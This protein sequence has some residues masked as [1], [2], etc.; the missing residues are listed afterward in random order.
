MKPCRLAIISSHPIQYYAP[1]FRY[2]QKETDLD[3]K[4]FYLKDPQAKADLDQGFKRVVQWDVPLLEGYAF[5]FVPKGKLNAVI[6]RFAPQAVLLIG[7]NDPVLYKFIFTWGRKRS[8]LIFKGDSHRLLVPKGLKESLRRG[9]ISFV[10]KQ[11]SAFLYVGKANYEYFRY[12][13]VPQERLFSSH[14]AVDNQRFFAQGPKASQEAREWKMELGIPADHKVVLFAGK[15]EDKKRPLDLLAA[16]LKADLSDVS[17]LFVGSGHLEGQMKQAA[18]GH[19]DIYFA[20]FQNQSFM[21]RTYA[22]CDLFV[23]PSFGRSETWGLCINEAMCMSKPVIVSS[24]VGCAQDLVHSA[25]NGLVFP[26]GDV[27]ALTAC[28]KEAFS[29]KLRLLEWGKESRKMIEDYDYRQTTQ[30]LVNAFK[31]LKSG[32]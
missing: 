13:H 14:H 3:I 19:K 18:Q 12:H 26:A 32:L 7:Y 1:W 4:I 2:I 11:F 9:F 27:S 10:F 8:P 23:L 25:K 21:P 22:V 6:E 17:L 28:L 31:S 29:D 24:H 30:G 16:F 15:F 20:S 5:E